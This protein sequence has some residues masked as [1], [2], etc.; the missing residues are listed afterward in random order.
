M[1]CGRCPG[2]SPSPRSAVVSNCGAILVWSLACLPQRC[3]ARLHGSATFSLCRVSLASSKSSSHNMVTACNNSR[4]SRCSCSSQ[5]RQSFSRPSAVPSLR[6]IRP[7][8]LDGLQALVTSLPVII[9]LVDCDFPQYLRHHCRRFGAARATIPLALPQLVRLSRWLPLSPLLGLLSLFTG[10]CPN[11]CALRASQGL[12]A[13]R[14]SS[15]PSRS[16]SL[17]L[18]LGSYLLAQKPSPASSCSTV[19]EHA[20]PIVALVHQCVPVKYDTSLRPFST[21]LSRAQFR[22][23]SLPMFP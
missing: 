22:S 14:A 12:R 6:P 23:L 8:L 11:S 17:A 4:L 1:P 20:R 21:C 13:F 5:T 16:S 9:C 10:F 3:H 18:A 19:L 15:R 7:Q 2:A